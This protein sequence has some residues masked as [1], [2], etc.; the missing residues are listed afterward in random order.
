[1]KITSPTCYLIGQ[2]NLLLECAKILR[3]NEFVIKGIISP[4]SDA[5]TW[6]HSQKIDW[7]SSLSEVNWK[8]GSVD[9]LFSIVNNEIIPASV[10]EH[11][12]TL[13]IN[14][15]DAPLSRYA[16]SSATSEGEAM[17]AVTWH[18][19]NERIDGGDILKQVAIPVTSDETAKSLNMKCVE[20]AI[21]TFSELVPELLNNSYQRISPNLSQPTYSGCAQKPVGKGSTEGSTQAEATAVT[22]TSKE[23][24]Q[25][26]IEWNSTDA[27]YPEHKTIHGLFEEQVDK[28]P[29]Q[30]ALIAPDAQL[31]Y[32]E[33]NDQANQLAYYLIAHHAIQPDQ[34]I[35][36]SLERSELM[37]IALLGILKS[38]GAYVPLDPHYPAKRVSYILRDT[39]ARVVLASRAQEQQLRQLADVDWKKTTLLV[40][41]H[42]DF[43]RELAQ[44]PALNPVTAT[45]SRHL[46][47]VMYTS[48]STGLPKGVLLEHRG[49]VNQIF[50]MNQTYPLRRSTDRILQ[51]TTYVFDISVWELFWANWYGATVVLAKPEGHAD[52]VYLSELIE[53]TRI[54]IIQFTP[55]MLNVFL[56]VIAN[57]KKNLSSLRHL[58]CIG[59]AL[60]LATVNKVQ[61]LLPQVKIHNI[62]GPTEASINV[63]FFDCTNQQAVYLG[64]PIANTRAY[65]LDEQCHLLPV[66]VSGELYIAGVGLA[67]GYL[68][69]PE[70]TAQQFITNPFQT[71]QEKQKGQYDRLYRTGDCA[72]R[73]PD[74]QLD[75]LGRND[76]QI[77]MRGYRIELGEIES[78]LNCYVGIKQALVTVCEFEQSKHPYLVGYYVATEKVEEKDIF[79]YLSEHLPEYMIPLYLM[80]LDA[81]PLTI[82]GKADKKAL[83][84]PIVWNK[85]SYIPPE[86]DLENQLV[87]IWSTILDVPKKNI[88]VADSFFKLG[89]NSLLLIEL[90]SQLSQVSQLESI[91][92][93]DLFKYPTIRQVSQY[94]ESGV[95]SVPLQ[96]KKTHPTQATEI[97]IISV[98]GAFSGGSD[99]EHYWHLIQSGKEGIQ[100]FGIDECR[101]AGISED[102]LQNPLF[103]PSSGHIPDIDKFDADFWGISP[104]D[105]KTL[106]PQIRL[107][108]EHCWYALEGSAY[109]ATRQQSNIGVFAAAGQQ[110]YCPNSSIFP[111]ATN[112]ALAPQVSY[113]LGLTGPA[114]NINTA[115][116]GSLVT[117]V[118]AC[119]NLAGGYCDLALA[120]GVSLLLPEERGY[121][122]QEGMIYSQDGHCR[123][124]DAQSSGTVFGSGVGVVLL[125][126]LS[127]AKRDNDRIIGVIKGYASNNDGD[128]KISYAAPSVIGQKECIVRA[129]E[130]AGITSEMVDYVECH[131]TGTRLGDPVEVKALD[132]AFTYTAKNPRLHPCVLGSVKANIGHADTASGIAGLIKVCKMLENKLIPPQINYAEPNPE[133][134]IGSTHFTITSEAQE[135]HALVDK[136]RIAAVS[137]F[138]IG[139]TNA[140]VIVAEAGRGTSQKK[141]H[142]VTTFPCHNFNKR[143]YWLESSQQQSASETLLLPKN[144][145]ISTP[146]W[147][148]LGKFSWKSQQNFFQNTFLIFKDKENVSFDSLSAGNNHVIFVNFDK[149]LNEEVEFLHSGSLSIRAASEGAYEKLSSYL[150]TNKIR[151]NIV[152]HATTLKNSSRPEVQ[153]DDQLESGFYSLFLIQKYILTSRL[154][155][156]KF[157]VLTQ[158]IAQI[159]GEDSIS[160]CNAAMVGALRAIKHELPEIKSCI[161]DCSYEPF[162]LQDL[163]GFISTDSHFI[164]EYLY[165]IRFQALWTESLESPESP[166]LSKAN[167]IKDGDVILITGGLGGLGLAIASHIAQKHKVIFVLVGLHTILDADDKSNNPRFTLL[168]EIKSQGCLVDIRRVDVANLSEVELLLE[169]IYTQYH[170]LSGI[171]HAAG[172]AP[173]SMSQ[174][175]FDNI[176]VAIRAKIHG[177]LYLIKALRSRKVN[178]FVLMSS[179]ASIMGDVNRIEYCAANSALDYLATS[180]DFPRGCRALSLNWPSWS[181]VGMLAKQGVAEIS[182]PHPQLMEVAINSVT[183][184]EGAELFYDLIQQTNYAQLVISK[185]SIPLIKQKLFRN[186]QEDYSTGR[187]FIGKK[188]IETNLSELNYRIGQLFCDI[189]G[190]E[191]FSVHDSFFDLGGNSLDAIDLLSQLQKIGISLDLADLAVSNSV[192]RIGYF[193]ENNLRIESFNKIVLP[194][195]VSNQSNKNVFFVHPVGGTVLPYLD[196]IKDLPKS[197]N[198]YGVQNI[199]IS[200]K[201]LLKADTLEELSEIYIEQILN[202]QSDGEYILMGSSMGG[203]IAYEMAAQLIAMNKKVKFVAMFD[204]WAFFSEHF[205]DKSRFTNSLRDQTEKYKH[206]FSNF[207]KTDM[208]LEASWRLMKLLLNYRPKKTGINVHLYKAEKLDNG[209]VTNGFCDDNGWQKYTSV[210]VIIHHIP[211]THTSIHHEPGRAKLVS[212]LNKSLLTALKD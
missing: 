92:V 68:N 35:A 170:Q 36:V 195:S 26:L 150:E 193:H 123:V 157:V 132:E 186:K 141:P 48:G 15:N 9:Y 76:T 39:D 85:Q 104:K 114:H 118:E 44:Q 41:D 143:S 6:A 88:G 70:L 27:P 91:T 128:R 106:D 206:L 168:E 12:H 112:D 56:Q 105:A 172:V 28:T 7:F 109:L 127:D 55:S 196:I 116:S 164:E 96:V 152:I 169:G 19:V 145:W 110:R 72:R 64:K 187:N 21:A 52:P 182:L 77:K 84:K 175:S 207:K 20:Q 122:Y 17:H 180:N 101:Q 138:G 94:F 100:F 73:L 197:Y 43:L 45:T 129:Q 2:D 188:I 211:G 135:W 190:L 10:L 192:Y 86:T 54:S 82:N 33:L 200:G 191:K 1:M 147:K 79:S 14:Y 18:V 63:L 177:S 50:W 137:S 160:P 209:H 120:G 115:C 108:L 174:R 13:A 210:P 125:K 29:H 212:L 57:E 134:G 47:Y 201:E 98:S 99:L 49:I 139:G 40:L 8:E 22:L 165:A 205:Y 81:I 62:Y 202:I 107:F 78:C 113:F 183:P 61:A 97:A 176:K 155:P 53:H 4:S 151:P 133:F 140:H 166:L 83:P 178:Y 154:A 199:N 198:Y 46:A 74:G 163:M 31:T 119:K 181:G 25:L 42:P 158:G 93:T 34:L 71:E 30:V 146:V 69:Q 171:I 203:T 66:G 144:E 65:V 32:R 58:F 149:T 16:G 148:R 162:I 5:K 38:G 173:L 24:H 95:T 130:M 156:S 179:L 189:L 75:Y 67:R 126:R 167:V 124:F 161:V 185:L 51:K 11:I 117:V 59:E 208:L 90:K 111:L 60:H 159:T 194:L 142:K 204:S 87:S 121:V 89:G 136:P 153:I 131:G 23:Q 102:L 3:A 37:L 184:D 80:Q 103:I